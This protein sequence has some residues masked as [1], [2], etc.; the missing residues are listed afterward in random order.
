MDRGDLVQNLVGWQLGGTLV[1][2]SLTGDRNY[3]PKVLDAKKV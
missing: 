3:K 1:L 2:A